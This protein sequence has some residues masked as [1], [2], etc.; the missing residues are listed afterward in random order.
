LKNE[1][2]W[3]EYIWFFDK[4]FDGHSRKLIFKYREIRE[5]MNIM[6]W[7]NVVPGLDKLELYALELM[8][9]SQTIIVDLH[10]VLL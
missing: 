6:S 9:N 10:Y 8:V 4:L 2:E 1:H 5:C 7:L 3:E